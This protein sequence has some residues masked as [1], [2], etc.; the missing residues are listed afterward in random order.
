MPLCH[1]NPYQP[2]LYSNSALPIVTPILDAAAV[3]YDGH[4]E[5]IGEAGSGRDD[6][7]EGFT[8]SR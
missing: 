4:R 3:R 8:E 6:V 2:A 7:R 1:I 5:G